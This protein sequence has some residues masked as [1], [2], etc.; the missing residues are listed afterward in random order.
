MKNSRSVGVWTVKPASPEKTSTKNLN[1]RSSTHIKNLT[2]KAWTA[3]TSKDK[4]TTKERTTSKT[5]PVQKQPSLKDPEEELNRDTTEGFTTEERDTSTKGKL[6]K[7]W[8]GTAGDAITDSPNHTTKPR[9]N[10]S[11]RDVIRD[12]QFHTKAFSDT[13]SMQGLA[14]IFDPKSSLKRKLVWAT[15]VLVAIVFTGFNIITQIAMYLDK[16]ITVRVDFRRAEDLTFPTLTICNNNFASLAAATRFNTVSALKLIRPLMLQ[17]GNGSGP[18]FSALASEIQYFKTVGWEVFFKMLAQ[19]M[20]KMLLKCQWEKTECTM[21]NFTPVFTDMGLCYS[22]N[23]E[24]SL[25]VREAGRAYGLKLMLDTRQDDYLRSM[26]NYYGAGF[27]VQVHAHAVPP[28]MAEKGVA[29]SPG[30]HNFLAVDVKHLKNAEPSISQCGDRKLQYYPESSAN[31]YSIEA[32]RLECRTDFIEERC[33]CRSLYMPNKA[34][35][36]CDPPEFYSCYAPTLNEYFQT[37]NQCEDLC[38]ETCA[39]NQYRVTPSSSPL[40]QTFLREVPALLGQDSDYWRHNLLHL[41]VY[42]C[43]MTHEMVEKQVAYTLLQLFCDVGGAFGL[44]LGAS[45][46]TLLEIVDFF[47][48]IV[49]TTKKNNGA[50]GG[51]G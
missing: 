14:P 20:T 7:A 9:L 10:R 39:E 30:H 43:S 13:V 36:I 47:L 26:D 15:I 38:P 17:T 42:L 45:L 37:S 1:P 48:C 3:A 4:E 34:L 12:H 6:T 25:Q 51:K 24:G 19:N 44:L 49:S 40:A 31:S 16:P 5:N 23:L 50:V 28:T 8:I 41:E 11:W 29:V 35:R 21:A 46:L 32:C 2:V 33:G 18:D 27:R 22:F